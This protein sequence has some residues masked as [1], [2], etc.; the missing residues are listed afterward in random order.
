MTNIPPA[1]KVF[2]CY[3]KQDESKAEELF[4]N[5]TRDGVN[6]WLDKRKL[7]LGDNW[8]LEIK[9]AVSE[10]DL[11][12]VLLRPGFDAIGFRQQ[13]VRWAVEAFQRRPIERGFIIPFIVQPCEELP[14]WCA[15]IHAGSNLFAP[16]SYDDVINAIQKHYKVKLVPESEKEGKKTTLESETKRRETLTQYGE[17][18]K[19]G[20]GVCFC[21][22]SYRLR[23]T[24]YGSYPRRVV[25]CDKCGGTYTRY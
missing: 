3:A 12:L 8:E 24:E 14:A 11:F 20:E 4:D 15:K 18:G 5:L 13:E 10:T 21:G 1:P 6:P 9:K 23:D 17:G 25:K 16:T 2:I 19:Y 22:G 7:V